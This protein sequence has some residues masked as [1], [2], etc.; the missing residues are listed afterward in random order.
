MT[1][2][3]RRKRVL[4]RACH[5]GFK[6]A[7]LLLGGFARARLADMSAA[8]LDAFEALLALPDPDLFAWIKGGAAAPAELEGP[9]LD[10]LRAFDIAG[11]REP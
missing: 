7:D 4:Y 2:D 10:A 3:V 8:E 1:D 11:R 6:E 9:L 5:R